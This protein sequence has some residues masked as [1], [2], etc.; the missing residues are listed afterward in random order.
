[1]IKSFKIKILFTFGLV[2]CAQ[3]MCS[4]IYNLTR[5][6]QD[7][8]LISSYIYDITQDNQGFLSI[9]TGEGLVTYQGTKFQTYDTT[10]GLGD[11]LISSLDVNKKGDLFIGH[12]QNGMSVKSGNVIR[13]IS[14]TEKIESPIT[15]ITCDGD[16]V[17]FGTRIGK[18]GIIND[19]KISFLELEGASFINKIIRFNSN[20]LVATD[21]GIYIIAGSNKPKI[22]EE[23]EGYFFTTLCDLN[24]V[25]F[26]AGNDNGAVSVYSING[27]NSLKLNKINSI[28]LGANLPI[29]TIIKNIDNKLVIGTWGKGVFTLKYSPK[30]LGFYEV[31]NISINNG[32]DNAFINGLFRDFNDNIWIGTFGGGLFKYADSHF[33][34]YNKKSGLNSDRVKSVFLDSDLSFLGFENGF[35]IMKNG[36]VD[37]IIYFN[38]KNKFFD[39]NVNSFGKI[40][41]Y[42]YLIA[43]ENNGLFLFNIK[44]KNFQDYFKKIGVSQYPKTI[45]HI[46]T[47]NDSVIY[48][49]T[50]DGLFIYKP[51]SRK[52]AKL[53]TY[54]GLPHNNILNT[55][56]DS[57][58]RLW[59]VAPKS[60]PG[61]L[62]NDSITLYKDLPNFKSFNATSI[63]EGNKGDIF[64]G[65]NGDGIYRLY[66]GKIKQYTISSGLGSNYVMGLVYIKEQNSLICAH[67]NGLTVFN[68]SNNR[69]RHHTRK[70]VLK[71]F[72]NTINSI[73]QN[74][75]NVYFGTQ[76]GLGVYLMNEERINSLPPKNSII[77]IKINE[78]LYSIS[79]TL[80]ELPYNQYDIKFEFI[81]IE[82]SDPEDVLYSF[83]LN[84]L[85]NGFKTSKDRIAEYFK[86]KEGTYEF[87]LN[88]KNAFGTESQNSIKIK[89]VIDKPIYKK[90]WFIML[91][92]II[93]TLVVYFL[94]KLRTKKLLSDNLILEKKIEEK[95]AD[96]VAI[97]KVLEDKNFDITSSIDYAKRIQTVLLP[98]MADITKH[99]DA[100]VYYKPRDIVSG[101]FYWY[102]EE[103]DYI[104]IAA[105]DCTGHGVPGAFMSL[106]GTTFLNQIMIELHNPLPSQV[107]LQLD[108]KIVKSLR[109]ESGTEKIR[110]GM[111]MC[112]CRINIK[113]KE[114]VFSGAG[115]PLYFVHN[116]EF[117]EF[118]STI[119]SIGGFHEGV[120]KQFIDET[121]N[122]SENDMVYMFSDGF[123]DQFGGDKTKRYSTKKMK[124]IFSEI[125]SEPSKSQLALVNM[126]FNNWKGDLEQMDDVLVIGIKLK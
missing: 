94:I 122:Y 70:T 86:I 33:R 43:T 16:I 100:F 29:K 109:Q 27:G 105:V 119:Y 107:L 22:F 41:Q 2:I 88:S 81:G 39:D 67:Q 115:R 55:F 118:K 68:L 92:I 71:A 8:G 104:Y 72:E 83:K 53:T 42:E 116:N 84:G 110:D 121:I 89:I 6:N 97:N 77:Q 56:L 75:S 49:S 96:I 46:N 20:L 47:T 93:G 125:Y 1:V 3:I 24:G 12:Y 59:F 65:T 18:V 7:D 13:R 48:I 37:S 73:V 64:I 78:K 26:V 61:M 112:L 87:I 66:D 106:I 19:N 58:N 54:E 91:L 25:S 36:N 50:I 85:E 10:N 57:K 69:I 11:N 98:H 99:L 38:S 9:A 123:G 126:E 21:N 35:G 76:Q 4:Q 79:D 114:L 101:D 51:S 63:C 52:V 40:G 103:N 31:E 74:R 95:T 113:T 17:Y 90:W 34:I 44:S 62:E 32:L 80:I 108:K 120:V 102:F 14:G 45:N 28:N 15:T 124:A 111:D 117:N 30:H 5:F 82:L 23:T 60:S